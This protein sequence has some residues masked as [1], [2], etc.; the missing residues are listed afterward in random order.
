M[1]Y[2]ITVGDQEFQIEIDHAQVSVNGQRAPVDLHWLEDHATLSLL[3]EHTSHEAL[4]EGYG[5]EFNVLLDGRVINVRVE[6][7]QAQR[8]RRAEEEF[9]PPS[10]QLTVQSPLP[11]L[12]VATPVS[13]GQA[14]RKG[15]VLIVLESMKMETE[16]LAP[17]DGQ[18]VAVHVQPGQTVKPGQALVVLTSMPQAAS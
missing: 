4:V 12:I 10:G 5:D 15:D 3:L 11:G 14:V 6:D 8:L 2:K 9:V 16:L 17:R 7:E 1:K 18:V 13:L